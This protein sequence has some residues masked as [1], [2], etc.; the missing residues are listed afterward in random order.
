[1]DLNNLENSEEYHNK[2]LFTLDAKLK[3]FQ[4][5]FDV[6]KFEDVMK[7]I[8][9]HVSELENRLKGS[10]KG[11]EKQKHSNLL[12]YL[13]AYKKC[14]ES[15]SERT[16]PSIEWFK[17]ESAFSSRIRVAMILNYTHLNVKHFLED[18]EQ[19]LKLQV[20]DALG[21]KDV[22]KINV[23][24]KA[25][26]KKDVAIKEDVKIVYFIKKSS[27]VLK[28][29]NFGNWFNENILTV[30]L[31][32]IQE[33]Q[34]NESG[35]TLK[36]IDNLVVNFYKYNPLKAGSWIPIPKE[37]ENKNA[38]INIVNKNDD[39]CFKWCILAKLHE[40]PSHANRVKKSIKNMK[41]N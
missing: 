35:W 1:M 7:T 31:T 37:I 36:S 20:E 16:G 33:F 22:F 26:F 24:L 12:Y 10:K 13:I 15:L 3:A 2:I 29:T 38:C 11:Q 19:L 17:L 25:H 8:D 30:L 39:E 27:I 21:R 34:E 6:E 5:K 14:F 23:E 32:K 18:A 41:T 40:K 4:E 9:H 28:S